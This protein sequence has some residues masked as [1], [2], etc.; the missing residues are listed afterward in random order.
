MNSFILIYERFGQNN[1]LNREKYIS[2]EILVFF[3]LKLKLSA[4]TTEQ[5]LINFSISIGS[6]TTHNV[7][8]LGSGFLSGEGHIKFFQVEFS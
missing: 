5:I 4:F 6:S 2:E 1:V 8:P 7:P 3:L